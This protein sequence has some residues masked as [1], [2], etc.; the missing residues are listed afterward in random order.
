[1]ESR[2]TEKGAT[3][4]PRACI[5]RL[6]RAVNAHDLAAM[7]DCFEPDYASEFPIHP[8]RVVGGHR[9]MQ[10][11][12]AQIFAAVPDLRADLIRCCVD[13]ETAWAEWEWQGRSGDGSPFWH[14]GVTLQGVR[15]G[16]IFW[17]RLYME[18][19]QTGAPGVT[20]AAPRAAEGTAPR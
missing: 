11:T 20:P 1:M 13:G 5:E 16:R 7:T 9:Q 12:W 2:Q 14:R 15:G 18:P 19:V 4:T 3:D 17:T 6:G 8:D 10:Q